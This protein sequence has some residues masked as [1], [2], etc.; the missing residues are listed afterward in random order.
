MTDVLDDNECAPPG[1]SAGAGAA[2]NVLDDGKHAPPGGS[3]GPGVRQRTCSMTTIARQPAAQPGRG[4]GEG[5]ARW[6]R[7]HHPAASW[8]RGGDDGGCCINL[9]ARTNALSLCTYHWYVHKD[10]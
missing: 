6:R 9:Y 3:A 1:G 5:R 4:V 10:L 8:G 7:A 2:R